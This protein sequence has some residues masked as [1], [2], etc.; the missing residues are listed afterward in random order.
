MDHSYNEKRSV[1]LFTYLEDKKMKSVDQLKIKIFADGAN[2]KEML[3]RHQN[4]FIQG[5]T[6]NPTLMKKAGIIDYQ[7]FAIDILKSIKDKPISF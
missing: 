1:K 3:D 6:T 5:F 4:S 2:K 7:A